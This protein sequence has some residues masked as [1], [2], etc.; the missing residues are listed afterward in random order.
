[1]SIRVVVLDHPFPDLAIERDVLGA[2]GAEVVDA[3]ATSEA[4]RVAAC[5]SA[6]AAL[7][8]KGP[9]THTVIGA[10]ERC[11]IICAYGAGYDQI[12]L[13]AATERGI[14]VANTPGYC[15]EEVAD[16]ALLLLLALARRLLPQVNA[17]AAS[18]RDDGPVPWTYTPY[19]PIRRLRGQVLGIVGFGRIGR[20][21]ARKAL[22]LGLRV[23]AA[24]P[25]LPPGISPEL[26]V[27]I[28]PL[29]ELL[30]Q[31]DFVS[32]H[33]P[34]LPS[35]RHLIGAPQLGRMKPTAYLI[36]C[37]R[38]PI[39]DLS[40]LLEALDA[41]RLA[42]AGLDVLEDEPATA[43]ILRRLFACPSVLV[44]PHTAWYSEESMED[45]QRQ[46]AETVAEALRGQRPRSVLNGVGG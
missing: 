22:G 36:N 8:E 15:D 25:L 16:H 10:M 5:R 28:V 41:G 33:A 30:E 31:V 18:A 20:T 6:D 19:V 7:L 29:D 34:L 1:M 12:D 40:A 39:V 43:E 14:M 42:G 2:L 17:L 32:L 13:A 35:T 45:R 4:D 26:G 27:P 38:G 11:K 24:D 37:A 21:L 23:V 44:T 46:A 9:V 3:G